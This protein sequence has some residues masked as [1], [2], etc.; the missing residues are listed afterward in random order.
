MFYFTGEMQT[1]ELC[2]PCF[3][4][5]FTD[6]KTYPIIKLVLISCINTML[7]QCFKFAIK[8]IITKCSQILFFPIISS[9]FHIVF[10]HWHVNVI[11]HLMQNTIAI[12]EY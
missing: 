3:V 1:Y 6:F 9:T 5:L 12:V 2:I 11:T 7:R 10:F 8:S 4:F